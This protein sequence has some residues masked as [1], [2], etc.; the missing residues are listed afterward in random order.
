MIQAKTLIADLHAVVDL[1]GDRTA[2]ILAAD[3]ARR[4]GAHL[5]GLALSFEPLIPIYPI[6]APIPTDIIVAARNAAIAEGKAAEA[7]FAKIAKRSGINFTTRTMR[8]IVGAG[9]AELSEA[10]RLS[11]LVIVGQ[12]DPDR[13]EPMRGAVI[14]ALLF[15]AAAPTLLVPYAGTNQ[16]AIERALVAWDGSAQASRALRSAMP[17]LKMATHVTVVMVEEAAKWARGMPGADVAE[18][19]ARHGLEVEVKRL[20]N[21]MGDIAATLLNAVA[22]EEAD[23]ML[24]G[25]YSH[26]R[27]RQALLGGVTRS[28]LKAATVPVLMVH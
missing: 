1:A 11:D 5:T 27:M 23:W 7:D 20:D 13:P 18:H 19:L 3:L 4:L 17:L 9:F 16:L 14:E 25:A 26:S 6:A 21:P 2:A 15:E 24:M 22:E 8:M 12:E 10:C 28:L